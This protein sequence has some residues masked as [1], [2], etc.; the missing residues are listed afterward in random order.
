MLLGEQQHLRAGRLRYGVLPIEAA[1]VQRAI[2]ARAADADWQVRARL[3]ECLRWF[4]L[5]PEATRTATGLLADPHW[6][7]RGLAV[8][9]LADQ[10]REK[11]LPVLEKIAQD[12][13]DEWVR[14]MARALIDRM[15]PASQPAGVPGE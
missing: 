9:L 14:R 8:R 13:A 6:L 10:H 3:A 4:V 15:R 1:A 11:F 7:V 2:L 12:D 5:D